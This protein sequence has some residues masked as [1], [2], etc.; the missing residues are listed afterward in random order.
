MYVP[1][2]II[3]ITIYRIGG[4]PTFVYQIQECISYS[5]AIPMCTIILIRKSRIINI[6][7]YILPAV[8][9]RLINLI[10]Y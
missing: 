7:V 5:K 6:C 2:I 4:L 9:L 1:N 3:A 8:L 10:N